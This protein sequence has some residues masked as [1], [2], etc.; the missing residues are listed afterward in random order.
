MLQEPNGIMGH[1]V[2]NNFV[3]F[4]FKQNSFKNEFQKSEVELYSRLS[5]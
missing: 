2:S 4:K 1:L 5:L 3:R